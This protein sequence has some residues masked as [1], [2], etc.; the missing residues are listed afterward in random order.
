MQ[1]PTPETHPRFTWFAE[2]SDLTVKWATVAAIVVGGWWAWHQFKLTGVE[3]GAV[4]LSLSTEVFP[5]TKDA[6]LVVLHASPKNVGKVPVEI[7]GDVPHTAFKIIVKKI[8]TDIAEAHTIEPE[9]LQPVANIDIL[10]HHPGGYVIE[11]ENIYDDVEAIPLAPG[12]YHVEARIE[13]DD[14][15]FNIYKIIQVPR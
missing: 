7:G 11:P 10:R 3:E 14:D 6:R 5:Y 2:V 4:D 13:I 12:T 1:A 9:P 15:Y 8:P